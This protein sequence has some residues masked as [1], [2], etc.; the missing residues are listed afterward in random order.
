LVDSQTGEQIGAPVES[1]KGSRI[2]LE[3]LKKWG[4]AKAFMDEWAKRF[5]KR[6]DE[7]QGY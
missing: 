4:D 3:G 6:L 7:T 2:S 1:Q 5:R